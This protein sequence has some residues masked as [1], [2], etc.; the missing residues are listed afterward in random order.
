MPKKKPPSVPRARTIVPT[1]EELRE[2]NRIREQ[3][4]TPAAGKSG[5]CTV[6]VPPAIVGDSVPP[7]SPT[8]RIDS[9]PPEY[10]TAEESPSKTL[11]P[12]GRP[13]K[14]KTVSDILNEHDINPVEELIAM[15]NERNEDPDHPDY[16]K[17]IMSRAE[18]VSIMREILKYQH[19][20]LKAVEHKG[21]PE[22]SKITVVLMM[23]DG[24]RTERDVAQRGKIIDVK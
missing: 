16:G 3:F 1:V 4:T 15:Y 8:I 18:R 23:P 20:T 2:R 21:D 19:P 10:V 11:S 17:F 22:S 5:S 14:Q 9:P 6:H 12:V 13:Q 7:P 24:S